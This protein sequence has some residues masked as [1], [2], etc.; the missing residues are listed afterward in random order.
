[1]FTGVAKADVTLYL[2]TL[3]V[4]PCS[5]QRAGKRQTS[6]EKVLSCFSKDRSV[7]SA[8]IHLG[9]DFPV[10]SK[11]RFQFFLVHCFLRIFFLSREFHLPHRALSLPRP[12]LCRSPPRVI[13]SVMG[14]TSLSISPSVPTIS[15]HSPAPTL[16]LVRV[17]SL[18]LVWFD[19][20]LFL[21]F[22]CPLSPGCVSLPSRDPRVGFD[23]AANL[24]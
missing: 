19:F 23:I 1:M 7:L 6:E 15:A 8:P 18:S 24:G 20:T 4:W 13:S 11:F 21:S 9:C 3:L 16:H 10:N 17:C 14:V 22:L 2:L 5:T 12:L